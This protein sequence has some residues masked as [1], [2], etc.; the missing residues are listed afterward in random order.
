MRERDAAAADALPRLGV[1]QLDPLLLQVGQRGVDV[2]DGVRYV[3]KPR[4]LLR[5]ELADGG[6]VAQRAEQ[7]DMAVAHVEQHRLDALRFHGLAVHERHP[8]RILVER[9]RGVEILHRDADVVDPVEHGR[10]SVFGP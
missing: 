9:D 3:V 8:E 4:S 7:L 6:V 2:R 10:R 5:E 1:D